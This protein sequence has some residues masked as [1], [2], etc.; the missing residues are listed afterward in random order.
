[1]LNGFYKQQVLN[2]IAWQQVKR[3]VYMPMP[4]LGVGEGERLAPMPLV[5]TLMPKQTTRAYM[6]EIRDFQ[7]LQWQG[8]GEQFTMQDFPNSGWFGN[9]VE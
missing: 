4:N 2:G 1:M 5:V 6:Q 3:A 7:Q 9:Y 8:R